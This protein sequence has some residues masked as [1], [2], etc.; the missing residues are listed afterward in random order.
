MKIHGAASEQKFPLTIVRVS[1]KV[2]ETRSIVKCLTGD[3]GTIAAATL[4]RFL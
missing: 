2:V 1:P 4:R 3:A